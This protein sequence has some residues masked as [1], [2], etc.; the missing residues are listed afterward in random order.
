MLTVTGTYFVYQKNYVNVVF[1][2][3]IAFRAQVLISPNL[4]LYRETRKIHYYFV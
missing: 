4:T 3:I 1:H 2:T